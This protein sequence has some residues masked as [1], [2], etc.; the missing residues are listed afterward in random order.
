MNALNEYK[1]RECA[2]KGGIKK[3]S[4]NDAISSE[5]IL[6]TGTSRYEDVGTTPP[7]GEQ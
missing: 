6:R 3:N 7:H 2:H 5:Q 4:A 1:S